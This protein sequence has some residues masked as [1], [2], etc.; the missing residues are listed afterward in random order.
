MGKVE[1]HRCVIM[2]RSSR[3]AVP[4]TKIYTIIMRRKGRAF[5]GC[6]SFCNY[7]LILDR[8]VCFARRANGG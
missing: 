8:F 6:F 2:E 5:N 4:R 1:R 7:S 3:K